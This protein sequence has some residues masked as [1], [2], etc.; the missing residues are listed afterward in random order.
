VLCLIAVV[1]TLLVS[2][3]WRVGLLAVAILVIA[4]IVLRY[5]LHGKA[6]SD[7]LTVTRAAIDMMLAGGNPYG[8]GF[9]ESTPPGAPFAYGPLALL[10]Y[11]PV[12]SEP[13]RL[14][15]AISIVLLLVFALRGR[16]LGLAIFAVFPPLIVTAADGSNDTSAGLLLLMA[17][18]LGP[19][20]PWAGAAALG[21]A[22][23][24]KPY[25][26]AWLL[27]L[28]GYA[29]V[30]TLIPFVAATV[31]TWGHTRSATACTSR[32][33]CIRCSASLPEAWS[34]SQRS[35]CR[36]RHAASFCPAWR[37]SWPPCSSAGGPRL[38]T[39]P[40]SHP[41]SAGT[42]TIG[43]GCRAW[44][45]P[46]TRQAGWRALSTVAGRCSE[47]TPSKARVPCPHD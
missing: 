31:V 11:L 6:F 13:Y 7:V 16:M 42:W 45:G 14:E 22:A 30:A 24:F 34:R 21:V 17:L 44:S 41:S 27:P 8:Q 39:W 5:D 28:V 2:L 25:A 20:I 19:R 9:P 29:G 40:P 3:R 37:S 23:A 33:R 10:W 38:R 26:L 43:S 12:K 4:G 1:A 36:G 46:A 15:L 32:R 47:P 18:W 35:R